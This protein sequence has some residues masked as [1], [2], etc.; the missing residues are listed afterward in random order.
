M[1]ALQ[2]SARYHILWGLDGKMSGGVRRSGCATAGTLVELH[3]WNAVDTLTG[4]LLEAGGGLPSDAR[5][6]SR[7]GGSGRRRS[8]SSNWQG[9]GEMM[10]TTARGRGGE[11]AASASG[12]WN[13]YADDD[14]EDE[15][16][17][18]DDSEI[19]N[20]AKLR[21]REVGKSGGKK[22]VRSSKKG[23]KEWEVGKADNPQSR[24]KITELT[25]TKNR[26]AEEE[27]EEEEEEDH[28]MTT[29]REVY[30][31]DVN[32]KSQKSSGGAGSDGRRMGGKSRR[33]GS[34]G[35]SWGEEGGDVEVVVGTSYGGWGAGNAFSGSESNN[36]GGYESFQQS[37]L[38]EEEDGDPD[39]DD[40]AEV[41][42]GYRYSDV[43]GDL[44]IERKTTVGDPEED[45]DEHEDY[46]DVWD[47][48]RN[49][50]FREI[51]LVDWEELTFDPSPLVVCA[52][53]R[54]CRPC[55]VVCDHLEEAAEKIWEQG[56]FRLRAVKLE[57][58]KEPDLSTALKARTHPTL[59]FIEDG[60]VLHKL[61]VDEGDEA[62]LPTSDDILQCA[63]Y[64]FYGGPKPEVLVQKVGQSPR[65][66]PPKPQA[67]RTISEEAEHRG[68][69][70][71]EEGRRRRRRYLYVAPEARQR[72]QNKEDDSDLFNIDE[73]TPVE[74][75]DS[76]LASTD[77]RV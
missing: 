44:T 38:V 33:S 52:F 13:I 46:S 40:E 47:R 15:D 2:I 7:V 58:N 27:E 25:S 57:I 26:G 30:V 43:L 67:R 42:R 21:R 59:Y 34:G 75:I 45:Y 9:W 65:G 18:D 60:R 11:M 56:K 19:N 39:W 17:D 72:T 53:S 10:A 73:N 20:A 70:K 1:A 51:G 22:T 41:G 48:E 28:E 69:I 31:V 5:A 62:S 4:A 23:G 66:R 16:E 32:K 49:K 64:F 63:A 55:S 71:G 36:S 24:S 54:W 76:I 68:G 12:R 50:H 3:P 14:D 77:Y 6:L 35:E 74:D 61:E 37:W 8:G 29:Q